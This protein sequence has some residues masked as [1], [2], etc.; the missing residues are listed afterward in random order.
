MLCVGG[1][2]WLKSG[3]EKTEDGHIKSLKNANGPGLY[4]WVFGQNKASFVSGP[5]KTTC[6]WLN[7]FL[8]VF[9]SCFLHVRHCGLDTDAHLY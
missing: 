4:F 2:C 3:N 5:W 9:D 8:T 6:T 7:A 1:R